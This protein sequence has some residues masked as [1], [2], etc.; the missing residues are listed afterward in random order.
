MNQ[1]SRRNRRG[2]DATRATLYR[3]AAERSSVLRSRD[4]GSR[5][6]RTARRRGEIATVYRGVVHYRSA[7]VDFD[8]RARA[9]CDAATVRFGG[10]F[11][12]AIGARAALAGLSHRSGAYV[13]GLQWGSPRSIE[14]TCERWDRT[15][16]RGLRVHEHRGLRPTDLRDM[17]GLSV[18][19]AEFVILQFAGQRWATIDKVE[20]MIY[21]ARRKRLLTLDSLEAF[22][23]SK[24]KRGRPGVRKLRAAIARAR[25]H[26]IPPESNPEALLLQCLRRN[27]F[28]EAQLQFVLNDG[29]G[30]F[31]GRFDAALAAERI[32][33][34]YQSMEWHQDEEALARANDRRL[35]AFG[36]GWF[37]IEARWWDLKTG[38]RKLV[39]A[40]RNHRRSNSR[41]GV[42]SGPQSAH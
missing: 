23:R 11:G 42:T 38:G 29:A 41:T 32:L 28:G 19:V 21:E 17:D 37:V 25:R 20:S 27:G 1:T 18:V 36:L 22:L 12:A 16:R 5:E 40:V 7:K 30:N 31:V 34:E 15:R 10:G 3:R 24:A 26:E 35:E 14:V 9:A 13:Y 6:R 8:A 39:S 2:A 4:L 33:I